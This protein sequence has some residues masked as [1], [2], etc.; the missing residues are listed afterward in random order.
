MLEKYKNV[1]KFKQ[2]DGATLK[3]FENILF[4]YNLRM[5]TKSWL[6]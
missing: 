1:K 2:N 3:I 4:E 6:S 5:T